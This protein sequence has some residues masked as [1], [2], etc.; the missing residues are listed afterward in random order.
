M[1]LRGTK[2]SKK[3]TKPLTSNPKTAKLKIVGKIKTTTNYIN[4]IKIFMNNSK[5][6]LNSQAKQFCDKF[7]S[8]SK[9]KESVQEAL[10]QINEAYELAWTEQPENFDDL[11]TAAEIRITELAQD[12]DQKAKEVNA[13][14][15]A[16]SRVG[17]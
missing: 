6:L 11:R 3:S 16:Q 4:S 13:K 8:H 10:D 14:T 7:F 17:R 2:Q 5:E 15:L 1:S 12:A 9:S